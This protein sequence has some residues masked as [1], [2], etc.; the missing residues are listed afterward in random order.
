M[1]RIALVVALLVVAFS[2]VSAWAKS[3]QMDQ[4]RTA[5]DE[6][7]PRQQATQNSI[8]PTPRGPVE[9]DLCVMPSASPINPFTT[10]STTVGATNHYDI[11]TTCGTGQTLFPLTGASLDLAYGVMTDRDCTVTVVAD[12]TGANWDLAL[13][14]LQAPFGSC[15]LLPALAPIPNA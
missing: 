2:A 8:P 13:Y 6:A 1:N 14:V 12:P 5:H 7:L 15:I 4:R 9:G 11:G 3:T 10:S